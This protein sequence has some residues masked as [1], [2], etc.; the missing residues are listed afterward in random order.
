MSRKA[1][2]EK[3]LEAVRLR[4]IQGSNLLR[5]GL[6]PRSNLIRAAQPPGSERRRHH[7]A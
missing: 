1:A 5:P 6:S 3:C 2:K 4:L 7:R